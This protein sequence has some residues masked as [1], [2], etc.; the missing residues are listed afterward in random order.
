MRK[1]DRL[2]RPMGRYARRL[3]YRNELFFFLALLFLIGV[4]LG[5]RAVK[6]EQHTVAQ[7]IIRQFSAFRRQE[8]F[9]SVCI[10]SFLSAALPLTVLFFSGLCALGQPFIC[11]TIFLRGLG[12]G[13]CAGGLYRTWGSEGAGASLLL[14]LISCLLTAFC[15]MSAGQTALRFSV[16]VYAA[17]NGGKCNA[18]R[19]YFS[20]FGLMF[21]LLL[22]CAAIDALLTRLILAIG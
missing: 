12:Y 9:S 13:F 6:S 20:R 3:F 22:F 5:G 15:L 14:L 17:M 2:S 18:M 21:L 7:Q 10:A 11:L 1:Q 16:G 4:L 8:N 19:T